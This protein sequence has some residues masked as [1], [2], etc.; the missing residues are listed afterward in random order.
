MKTVAQVLSPK[1]LDEVLQEVAPDDL[2][3]EELVQFKI[4]L[5]KLDSKQLRSLQEDLKAASRVRGRKILLRE[6]LLGRL[7]TEWLRKQQEIVEGELAKIEVAKDTIDFNVLELELSAQTWKLGKMNRVLRLDEQAAH[8]PL[9]GMIKR[10][11]A[12]D[13]VSSMNLDGAL[14]DERLDS[15]FGV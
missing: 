14:D 1:V 4:F 9:I 5:Q 10:R 3:S 2:Q 6:Q 15:M 11:E 12:D 7:G 8:E 13:E